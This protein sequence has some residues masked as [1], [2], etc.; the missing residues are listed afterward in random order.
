MLF[1]A[2]LNSTTQT[3]GNLFFTKFKGIMSLINLDF[4]STFGHYE[5]D[6]QESI[7]FRKQSD[8]SLDV[9]FE[10]SDSFRLKGSPEEKP[11]IVTSVSGSYRINLSDGKIFL[12]DIDVQGR[13]FIPE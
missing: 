4:M 12:S 10:I 6:L 9:S 7:Q 1:L 3:N 8:D 5:K 11:A 2:L 13:V